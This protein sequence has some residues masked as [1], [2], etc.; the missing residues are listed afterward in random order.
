MSNT[1]RKAA[2]ALLAMVTVGAGVL[3]PAAPVSSTGTDHMDDFVWARL[4][5]TKAYPNARGH[6]EYHADEDHHHPGMDEEFDVWVRGVKKL[7]GKR[8]RVF[9]HGDLMGRM[10]VT[11][12]GRAHLHR[13]NGLP[14]IQE[15][16]TVRV[17]TKSGK[18]VTYGKFRSH[19]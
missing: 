5:H 1:R 16:W 15:G 2:G 14:N 12:H 11:Q 10:R 6:A 19:M 7:A 18:L 4:H 9:V 13:H 3:A 17:R 8:V